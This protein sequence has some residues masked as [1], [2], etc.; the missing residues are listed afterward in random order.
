MTDPVKTSTTSPK[1]GLSRRSL[2]KT[3]AAATAAAAFP[4][5][6][7][8]A[9]NIKDI[10][11]VHVGQS[12]ST[13][14]NIAE[15]ANKDL[16]F[17][18]EMQTSPD[19]TAQVNRML[20]QPKSIDV[21]DVPITNMKYFVGRGVLSPV[22]VS[23]YKWYDKTVPIFTTGKYPDG[24]TV[25]MQGYSPM[26]AQYYTDESGSEYAT[27]PTDWLVGVP[28]YYNADTLGIRPDLI[29]RPIESWAELLNP[30]FSGKV[31]LQDGT[32]VGVP[33]AA[34]ALQAMGDVEYVDKGNM[35]RAEIDATIDKLIEYKKEGHFR[36]FW[37]NFDQ[38]VQLMASGE[39]VLQSMWS[40][41][42]TE[43]R[44]RGIEC[45]YN[46][47]K[48]GYRAWYIMMM[49]MAHLEG[50]QRECAIEYM[51]WFNSGWAGAFISR[52]G[53]YNSVPENVKPHMTENEYGYWYEGKEATEDI[54]NP[55]GKVME[56]AGVVRDG[57]SLWD[58]MGNIG[59][60]NTLMDEDR[61]LV[62]RWQDF[63]AA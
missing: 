9:Q 29:G 42:V 10:K 43:V 41:A 33:D 59:I 19:N 25:S 20:T 39:V 14:P 12:Y 2:L 46:G 3:G 49:P 63:L 47:M 57:G 61:Y 45:L 1:K 54:L 44:T 24:G 6:M 37:T 27:E 48:E 18:V 50:L 56:K 52:Q 58:R 55:F 11:I 28:L 62:R 17:T 38:S 40:P 60:W 22:N 26:K 35:T 31:A 8:W 16:D 21:S 5:P 30:E 32:G 13:I 4:A 53:F 23:E 36:S 34:M 7:I 15:Q 51:N